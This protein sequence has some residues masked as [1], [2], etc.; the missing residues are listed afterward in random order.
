MEGQASACPRRPSNTRSNQKSPHIGSTP[1]FLN[2]GHRG[3]C[4]STPAASPTN[5]WRGKLPLARDGQAIPDPTKNRRTSGAHPDSSAAG[6]GAERSESGCTECRAKRPNCAP[7]PLRRRRP[8]DG[9]CPPMAVR[10]PIRSVRAA[11]GITPGFFSGSTRDGAHVSPAM[12][13]PKNFALKVTAH[14]FGANSTTPPLSRRASQISPE[15]YCFDLEGL[16]PVKRS[17]A[18]RNFF[19]PTR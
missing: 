7:P 17:S 16:F 14:R 5:Q 13:D 6:T 15:S 12:A 19:S 10:Y 9:A 4:P 3:L 18:F 11:I 8:P 1:G 2:G